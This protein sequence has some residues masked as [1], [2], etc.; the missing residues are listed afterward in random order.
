MLGAARWRNASTREQCIVLY[1]GSNP[2]RASSLRPLRGLRLGGPAQGRTSSPA[3][4]C[5]QGGRATPK[6]RKP[7]RRLVAPKRESRE[8]GSSRRSSQSEGGSS[9]R[10]SQSEGGSS[11]RSSQSEGGKNAG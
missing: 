7:R 4:V 1:P 9:R 8:G 6:W 3:A 2:G 5:E 11:R 10:S